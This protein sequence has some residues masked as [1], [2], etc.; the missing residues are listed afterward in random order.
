MHVIRFL[1]CYDSGAVCM[2]IH[3]IEVR[4]KQIGDTSNHHIAYS[5]ETATL[6]DL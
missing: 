5:T 3:Y 4:L 2:I 6:R 1:R